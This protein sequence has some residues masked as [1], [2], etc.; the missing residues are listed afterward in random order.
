MS[1]PD[2]CAVQARMACLAEAIAFVEA[3][4][5]DRDVAD[6]DCLRL[7]LIVEELFSNTVT[8]GH[9]GDSDALVRLRLRVEPTHLELIYEDGAPPFDPLEAVARTP[10]DPAADV[11]DRPVGGLGLVLVTSLPERVDYAREGGCN[12]LRLTLRRQPA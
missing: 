10:V 12:R 5:L 7:S 6:G 9:G 3:V 1:A 11:A 8:H 2:A 4:C